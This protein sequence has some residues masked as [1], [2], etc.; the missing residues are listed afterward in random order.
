MGQRLS[1]APH[2]HNGPQT[3]P[4]AFTENSMPTRATM[5]CKYGGGSNGSVL[6]M[7]GNSFL[8]RMPGTPGG[9]GRSVTP[10]TPSVRSHPSRSSSLPSSGGKLGFA[11][12]RKRYQKELAEW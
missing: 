7:S 10:S 12:H 3:S 4:L 11:G 1:S 6:S 9:I 8:Q 2:F 5:P